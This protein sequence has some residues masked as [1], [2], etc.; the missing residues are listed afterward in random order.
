MR[1][2]E[3]PG[4]DKGALSVKQSRNAVDFRR[5]D[6]FLQGH[7]RNDGGDPFRQHRFAGTGRPDHEHVVPAGDRHFDRAL[8][9][10]LAFDVGEIDLVILVGGEELRSDR[11]APA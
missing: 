10:R 2:A 1:R 11:R 4:G 9:V 6:R 3:R 8:H 5:L 7:R